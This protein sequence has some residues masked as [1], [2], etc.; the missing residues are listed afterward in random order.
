[1]N[2]GFHAAANLR[3]PWQHVLGALLLVVGS[4][5]VA[6]ASVPATPPEEWRLARLEGTDRLAAENLP[7]GLRAEMD[8]DGFSLSSP[9]HAT[10]RFNIQ[11]IGRVGSGTR[12]FNSGPA[13]VVANEAY[14]P[15]TE[16][17]VHYQQGMDG[18]RQN[19]MVFQPLPGD[20]AVFVEIGIASSLT[21]SLGATDKLVFT[22]AQG[23]IPF[24]YRDLHCWD[25][26]KKPLSAHFELISNEH[27]QRLLIVVADQDATYPILIDPV[28]TTPNTLLIG[29]NANA[30]FGFSV[31]TA[32]DLNGDGRSD[33]AVSAWQQIVGGANLAGAVYIYYGTNTGISTVAS[34]I[35]TNGQGG[36][37]FGTAVST[38]GDVNGD[39]FSDL[40][41][42]AK[43]W[44]SD[45]ATQIS[46]GSAWIYHGSATGI[47]ATPA[48][49][50]QTDHADDNFGTNVA[51]LGDINNDGFSD[52]IIGAWLSAYGQFQ[53]GTAW[54]YTGSA[55]GINPVPLHRLERN[56]AG[57]AV[58]RCVNGAG[59]INGDGYSDVIVGASKW[60]Y[61]GSDQGAAFIW[62][63]SAIGLGAG[64]NPAP[65]VTLTGQGST[66]S[67]FGFWASS[68]GDLNGDGYS[69][70]AVG[71]YSED[72]GQT[73]EGQVY[74]YHG[75]AAGLITTPAIVLESNQAGCWMG[76]CTAPGGDVNGDG[77]GDL[78]VG[79]TR[80]TN[81]EGLEGRIHVYLGSPT[82]IAATQNFAMELNNAGAQ[83]GESVSSAGDVNGDGYSD[84]I[85]GARVY[86][87]G[88]AAAIFHGGPYSTNLLPSRTWV[89]GT[90]AAAHGTSVANAGDVNGDGYA[91][92]LVGA[93]GASNGQAN[94]GQA[95]LYYGS[96]TGLP[97]APSLTLEANVA[98]ARFG[99]SVA[100]AGDVNGDGYA[101]VVVGAPGNSPGSAYVFMGSAGGL[102]TSPAATLSTG[103]LFGSAVST[104]GD[105]NH[106]GFAEVIIGSPGTGEAYVYSGSAGGLV[107]APNIV[108]TEPPIAGLFGC[109]V[110]TAGDVNGDGYS[111]VIVGA[112][113]A[114]NNQANEGLAYVYHGSDLGL[115][116]PFARMLEST[117]ASANFGVSVAGAGDVNGDGYFDV[118][119][120]ADLWESGQTDEGGAF[121]HHG[122]AG[123]VLAAPTTTLQRNVNVG[124]F[125]RSVAEAGDVNGDGY[126]DIIVGAPLMD[127]PAATA[128]EGLAF[129]FRGSTTGINAALLDQLEPNIADYRFGSCVGGGGDCDGDGYSDVYVGAPNANPTLTTEGSAFWFRGA[130][131]RAL[132]RLS[133]QYDA[134]LIT[135]LSTNSNDQT[136]WWLFGIGHRARSP[137]QRCRARLRWEVVF[138]G[139]PFSNNPITNSVTQT[140]I[141]AA[142]TFL[143]TAGVEIKQSVFKAAGHLRYKW[144]VRSE[145]DLVKLIDGQRFSRW[146]Y[147]YANGIGDIGV[148]PVELISFTGRN[149]GPENVLQWTTA[150][151][152]NSDHYTVERSTNGTDF[153]HIGQLAAAGESQDMLTYTWV[154][155]TPPSTAA[156][157]RLHMVDL[158]GH[159]ELSNTILLQ[160]GQAII[161]LYPNPADAHVSVLLEDGSGGT[162]L[163][164]IGADG[165]MH[166][167]IRIQ[168]A[169]MVDLD[170]T[171]LAEGTY[172]VVL[173]SPTGTVLGA[174]PL[175]KE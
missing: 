137:I 54:V 43:T 47:S 22:D 21:A 86:G 92:A 12:P 147:G 4:R 106:D 3:R 113:M 19:F 73:D 125:G 18:L 89:G 115:I 80:F 100:S 87:S 79:I 121:V 162:T 167:D 111:D 55:T 42:G 136:I 145:Y 62:Y 130:V 159:S 68:A 16:M 63:G 153:L 150:S 98:N 124:A 25:A 36:A 163:Q 85:S 51:C 157:Y 56:Q 20:G 82:G 46:E 174:L 53:E 160:R 170:V 96:A 78:L 102:S 140:G 13:T 97:A 59:D 60:T 76:R 116:T 151:E 171:G 107:A 129:V 71:A 2:L 38:A 11:G 5:P 88:G 141:G 33:V 45:V 41:V 91:D 117:V 105:V 61:G 118:V 122:S 35:L 66:M 169:T 37:F 15:G 134:D 31:A 166:R 28:S 90:A 74:V 23:N 154:D 139:Q 172:R 161:G 110:A 143:P 138:E 44:E 132:N 109:A 9:D 133:R 127:N 69:D 40:I 7:A 158:D 64:I 1:M 39:G 81:P 148:L 99:E 120:G 119:V 93:P 84:I 128:D 155:R 149:S 175:V 83:F 146:F 77:Y 49:Q 58:G 75:S 29:A 17:A 30:E 26:M 156:Y 24:T 103:G 165:M 135:P 6:G 34:A 131:N 10:A 142:W 94:E 173:R 164:V 152:Q 57:A 48:V 108:L 114:T 52:I 126:A 27:E 32:G 104:A 112:R 72:N 101:D 95:H 168:P 123:G 65:A 70:V 67:Y 14:Y 144:R 50:L 8:P